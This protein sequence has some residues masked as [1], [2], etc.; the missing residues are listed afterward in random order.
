MDNHFNSENHCITIES[1]VWHQFEYYL[2]R[3]SCINIFWSLLE[4]GGL[5]I[6]FEI[7]ISILRFRLHSQQVSLPPLHWDVECFDCN[8]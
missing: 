7:G 4:T 2:E 6:D 1:N 8:R 5:K 3:L